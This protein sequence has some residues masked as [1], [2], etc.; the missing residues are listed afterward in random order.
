MTTFSYVWEYLVRPG[1]V[2]LFEATYS[3]RDCESPQPC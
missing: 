3:P 2:D 1:S